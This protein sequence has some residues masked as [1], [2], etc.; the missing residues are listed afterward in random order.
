M[1]T[2]KHNELAAGNVIVI[3]SSFGAAGT[4]AEV[5]SP[6]RSSREPSLWIVPIRFP[7]DSEE[8]IHFMRDGE[9][10]ELVA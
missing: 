4:K 9:E 6:S 10:V 2:R 1:N 8:Y 3:P 5:A 7:G